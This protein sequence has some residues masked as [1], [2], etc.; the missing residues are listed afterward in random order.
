VYTKIHTYIC[1]A[2]I[3]SYMIAA[4]FS[5]YLRPL[6]LVLNFK[7]EN[8]AL[9]CFLSQEPARKLSFGTRFGEATSRVSQIESH[10]GEFRLAIMVPND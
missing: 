4:R 3:A 5:R 9:H 2:H 1:I 7:L 6:R 10:G 8:L